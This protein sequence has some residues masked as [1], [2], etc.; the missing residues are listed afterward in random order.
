MIRVLVSVNMDACARAYGGSRAGI[1]ALTS[2]HMEAC[3]GGWSR[4]V[5]GCG[6]EKE[7]DDSNG[8]FV[9]ELFCVCA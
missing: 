6:K 5:A 2:G 8:C 1:W 4:V 3:D 7:P 9:V